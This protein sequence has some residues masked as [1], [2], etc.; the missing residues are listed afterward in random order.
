MKKNIYIM[1]AISFLQGMVFYG[2]VATLYRQASG[3]TIFQITL[4]ESVCLA[5]SVL[6]E[7][8]WG[9]VADRIGYRRTMIICCVMYF[10]SKIVFWRADS[11]G[12]FMLERVMLGVIC[13]G[14]S[15]VDV[16]VLYLS[17]ERGES[18]KVFGIYN[19]L[20]NA[21]LLVAAGVYAVFI[22]NDYRLAGELTVFSYA[23]AALLAFGLGEVKRPQERHS[24]FTP[25]L[26]QLL[27][28]TFGNRRLLLL[29]V[30]VALISETHQTIT[31]FLN[32]LQYVKAGMSSAEIAA[33]FTAMTLLGLT[34]GLSAKITQKFGQKRTGLGLFALCSAACLALALTR[35]AVVSVTAVLALRVGYSVFQP[36]QTELQNR[37]ITSPDR[38]TA[39]SFNAVLVDTVS[40]SVSLVFGAV[41]Q[42]DVS[43][44]MFFG[45]ALCSVGFLLYP[46]SVNGK[47]HGSELS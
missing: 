26:P 24:G 19:N 34:G 9:I 27:R 16:S 12:W 20:G 44:A 4:I 22:G 32:Q 25:G 18:Q 14:L 23:A 46:L 45:C 35:N 15:G 36:L 2:P 28:E 41:A 29:L 13:A 21:G 30:A 11:F 37:E 3:I 38:A 31:V 1:Y 10:V 33:A 40:I 47:L 17:C 39:L 8:P 42:A 6:L 43:M 5:L 7:L